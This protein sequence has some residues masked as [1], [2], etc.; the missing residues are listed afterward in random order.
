MLVLPSKSATKYCTIASALSKAAENRKRLSMS[1]ASIE[2]LRTV[3]HNFIIS[4]LLEENN[5]FHNVN[6]FHCLVRGWFETL[7]D[8]V[9]IQLSFI[10]INTKISFK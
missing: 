8:I 4:F 3:V 9:S 7:S 6:I 5:I 1:S 2:V 10:L